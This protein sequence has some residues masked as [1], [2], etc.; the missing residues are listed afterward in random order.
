M[1]SLIIIIIL[2]LLLIYSN[3]IWLYEYLQ[4]LLKPK[5]KQLYVKPI[6]IPHID[7]YKSIITDYVKNDI[8]QF[9]KEDKL[10][11]ILL[12]SIDNGKQ[13]RPIILCSVYKELT[14]DDTNAPHIMLAA[15][16]IEYIHSASLI[17]D[18]IMDMD[19]MRRNKPSV[20]AKYNQTTA[21]IAASL[22]CTKAMLNFFHSV[23]ELEKS[24]QNMNSRLPI[25]LGTYIATSLNELNFGQYMDVMPQSLSGFADNIRD[26]QNNSASKVETITD[27]IHKKTSSLFEF[28]FIIPWLFA[29]CDKSEDEL[30]IGIKK[31]TN[32]A[33]LF[34]FL[35]QVSDDFEDMEQDKLRNGKNL[36]YVN[37]IGFDQAL[38]DYFNHVEQFNVA[39]TD[40]NIYNDVLKEALSYLEN[41]VIARKLE[42][43]SK[44]QNKITKS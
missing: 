15:S 39:C 9:A 3:R 42:Y 18:D 29:N 13:I 5:V 27:I 23:T 31:M 38:K 28:C 33:R 2:T 44:Y 21:Q 17:I 1:F 11:N 12:Y 6:N 25:I 41:K 37:S 40:L 10:T 34:G 8:K 22:L 24:T 43:E 7:S 20:Y 14:N 26:T 30:N 35:F 36:N 32:V 4:N 19:T 16:A